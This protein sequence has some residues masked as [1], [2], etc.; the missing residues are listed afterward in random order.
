MNVVPGFRSDLYSSRLLVSIV[1]DSSCIDMRDRVARPGEG[2]LVIR[3]MLFCK[4]P[5]Y[6]KCILLNVPL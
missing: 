2:G 5:L 6:T 1:V 3:L 4:I